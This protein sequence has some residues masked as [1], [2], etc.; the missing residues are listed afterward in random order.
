MDGAT[1][2]LVGTGEQSHED[3]PVAT[4]TFD[5]PTGILAAPDGSI[6]VP[7]EHS[8]RKLSTDGIV[9]TIAGTGFTDDGIDRNEAGF[10]DG[11]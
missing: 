6:Y 9:T 11:G 10:T 1:T 4:A 2:T 8:I 7:N 3:D 5:N